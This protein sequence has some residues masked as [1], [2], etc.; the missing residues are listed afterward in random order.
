MPQFG[1]ENE[2]KVLRW[3]K[4]VGAPVRAGDILVEVEIDKAT[5]EMESFNSG[6]LAMILVPAGRMAKVAELLAVLASP[7]EDPLVVKY[8]YTIPSGGGTSRAP[9]R[10][11]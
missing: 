7:G 2:N 11:R 3:H 1:T 9:G 10:R 4:S 5:L 6:T 8:R